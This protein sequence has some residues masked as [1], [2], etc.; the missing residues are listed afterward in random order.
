M[1]LGLFLG[2]APFWGFQ[3]V[4]TVSMAVLLNLNKSLAFLCSNISIPPMIP[5][6]LFAS[7][8]IGA[9]F[10]GGNLLPEGDINLDFVKNNLLQYLIGSFVLAFSVAF[11]LGS[12]TYLVLRLLRKRG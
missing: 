9:F 7:F 1:A 11:L 5:L 6:L 4:L 2:I 8:K 10:V 3:T 12:L